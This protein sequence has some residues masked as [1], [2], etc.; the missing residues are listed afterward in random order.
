MANIQKE[1]TKFFTSEEGET[2]IGQIV[3]NCVNQALK[4]EIKFEDGRSDPGRVVEKSEVWNILDWIVKYLPRV[5]SAVRGC[6]SD[7]AQARNRSN[8]VKSVLGAIMK[9]QNEYQQNLQNVTNKELSR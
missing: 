7:S 3:L 8:E 1:L 4:R 6:Q 2:I 9:Q 5:E